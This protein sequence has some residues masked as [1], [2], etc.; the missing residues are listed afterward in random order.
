[1]KQ[2][3]EV[4]IK[5]LVWY[6]INSKNFIIRMNFLCSLVILWCIKKVF[7]FISNWTLRV[8]NDNNPVFVKYKVTVL[9]L[10]REAYFHLTI[11]DCGGE[12]KLDF[13]KKNSW[14]FK[15]GRTMK[16]F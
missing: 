2:N 10:V 3:E 1:M 9:L 13:W 12:M 4:L 11:L 16:D 15:K 6:D 5:K 14:N 8:E 7:E